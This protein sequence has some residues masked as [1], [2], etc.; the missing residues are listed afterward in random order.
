MADSELLLWRQQVA[1]CLSDYASPECS[2]PNHR[3]LQWIVSRRTAQNLHSHR[4]VPELPTIP[5]GRWDE[6]E[7][8]EQTLAP[9]DL[10]RVRTRG[11]IKTL[12]Q[13]THTSR[14]KGNK[15]RNNTSFVI[16]VLMVNVRKK[17]VGCRNF[18]KELVKLKTNYSSG[19]RFSKTLH[20]NCTGLVCKLWLHNHTGKSFTHH[21]Y[22]Q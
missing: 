5:E 14:P 15:I 9:S 20:C 4:S 16:L 2:K 18:Q 3:R 12:G 19:E 13:N 7:R 22:V 17:I 8:S 10:G 1:L 6:S 11:A 21:Q